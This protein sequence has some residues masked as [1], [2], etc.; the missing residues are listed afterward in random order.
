MASTIYVINP[1]STQA[2]TQGFDQALE[3]LRVSG[4]PRIQCLTLDCGP[5]GVQTQLDVESVTLPLIHLCRG[6]PA[7]CAAVVIA[8]FSDPGLH[9]VREVMQKERG[10]PV[11]GISECG[12]LTAMTL[13]QKFGVIAILQTSIARHLRTYGAMGI[14]DRLAGEKAIDL[15]VT[16]MADKTTT[17]QRMVDVGNDLVHNHGAQV[18]VM[19]CAGMADFREDLQAATGVPVVEPTQAAVSM[20]IGRILLGW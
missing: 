7:D 15:G 19:G 6:L 13:G 14:N 17:L 20:A 12:L 3:R 18:L 16:E 2:V 5:S 8:C 10:I 1:N 9:V 11:F 4:A